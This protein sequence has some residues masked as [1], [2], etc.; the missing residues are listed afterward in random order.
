MNTVGKRIKEERNRL[1]WSQQRL[2]DAISRKTG[3]AISREAISQWENGS[4]KTQKPANLLAAAE[5]FDVSAA[6]LLY[7]GK[8]V[9]TVSLEIQTPAE[10]RRGAHPAQQFSP[11]GDKPSEAAITI[12]KRIDKLDVVGKVRI[13]STLMDIESPESRDQQSADLAAILRL[14]SQNGGDAPK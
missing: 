5:I 2:A 7:G 10:E 14:F 13:L 1:G 12:A 6:Y 3:E 8:R 11:Q 4:S 9:N